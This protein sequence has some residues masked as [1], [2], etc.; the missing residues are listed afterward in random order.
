M[1]DSNITKRVLA[2]AFKT[3]LEHEPFEKISVKAICEACGMNRKSFYYHFTDKYELVEWIYDT[4]FIEVMR[5]E[6]APESWELIERLCEFFAE[7]Q[8]FYAKTL[9]YEGQNSFSS[10]FYDTVSAMLRRAAEQAPQRAL[11]SHPDTEDFVVAFFADAF[12]AS[13]K[14]WVL[15]DCPQNPHE[16]VGLLRI[17]VHGVSPRS[18]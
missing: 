12:T 17:C 5:K 3:L 10:Y 2:H 18:E 1:P 11:W 8:S 7:N 14:R 15:A 9:A 16:F 13:I 6:G 4:E